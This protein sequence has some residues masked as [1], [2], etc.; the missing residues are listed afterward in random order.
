MKPRIC[1]SLAANDPSDISALIR[2]AEEAE[3]DLI[4]IRLDYLS[5]S[6]S[7]ALKI[8]EA[9]VE[10]S[11]IPMIATNRDYKQ[12]GLK[13]QDEDSRIRLLIQAA[14]AGFQ[15]VD[16]ELTTV[17]VK[18]I[19]EKI[20]SC[21]AKPIVSFHDFEKTPSFQ[22]ME[23]IVKS[24]IEMGA[25]V[26]KLVTTAH[27]IEDNIKCLMLTKKMSQLTK[28][29]CFAM[30]SKGLLSRILSPVFGG[31]FTFASTSRAA[32]TAPGQP[33]IE[34]LKSL[35]LKLGVYE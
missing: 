4:E 18:L 21:G 31:Y 13:P 1:V 30:G 14:K 35:Y 33:S 19:V 8:L 15:Y 29:V 27:S 10:E 25:E 9:F 22:K 20:K 28:I 2:K 11:S 34:D 26:C 7:S 5:L 6:S 3:A 17:E 24:E 23:R 32:K 12:G 16:I